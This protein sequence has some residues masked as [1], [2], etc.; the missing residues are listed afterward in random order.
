V[1]L[2][3]LRQPW[4]FTLLFGLVDLA[5]AWLYEGTPSANTARTRA[6]G[7]IVFLFIVVALYLF[8]DVM[9]SEAGGKALPRGRPILRG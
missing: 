6:G 7:A 2:A 3:T 9:D 8:V 4:S 5:S 1:N